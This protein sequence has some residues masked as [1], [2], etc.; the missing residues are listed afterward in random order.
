MDSVTEGLGL[1]KLLKFCFPKDHKQ[2]M[3]MAQYLAC[4]GGAL[5][6]CENWCGDICEI[7]THAITVV[8]MEDVAGQKVVK[9]RIITLLNWL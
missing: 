6:H 3:T 2:I 7:F 5:S 4:D 8:R 9:G 1:D